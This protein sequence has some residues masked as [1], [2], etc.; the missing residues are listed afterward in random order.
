MCHNDQEHNLADQSE[1][2]AQLKDQL[3]EVKARTAL[4]GKYVKKEAQVAVAMAQKRTTL[5]TKVCS[6]V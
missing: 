6:L 3:Q 1:I 2:I 4:E 5:D